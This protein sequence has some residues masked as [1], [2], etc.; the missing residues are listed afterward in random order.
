MDTDIRFTV[1]QRFSNCVPVP[2]WEVVGLLGG[3]ASCLYE[4]HV[5]FERSISATCRFGGVVVSVFTTGPK[6]RRS[7]TGQGDWFFRAI[8]I[9]TIRFGREVKLEVPCRKILQH[10]KDPL[11][12]HGDGQINSHSLLP[13]SYSLQRCLCWLTNSVAQE[14]EGSSPHSQQPATGPCSEPV[15][16]SP[17]PP[18]QSP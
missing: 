8:K 10:V 9:R 18:T 4:G 2:R 16:S 15:E 14:P 5:Y 7:E 12:S 17:H 11:N 6:G 13:F 1:K 3:G